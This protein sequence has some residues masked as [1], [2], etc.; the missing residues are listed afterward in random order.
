MKNLLLI[1]TISISTLVANGQNFVDPANQWNVSESQNFGATY[2]GIYKIIG[3][4]VSGDKL[5]NKIF[6]SY[7]STMINW[8]YKGLLRE[9]SN[10]VYYIPPFGNNEGL[11]YDFT[12]NAGDTIY[13]ISEWMPEPQQFVCLSVDSIFYDGAYHKRWN[14]LFP[15]EQWIEGIGSTNGPLVS[16]SSAYVSDLWFSLLCFHWND[17]LLYMGP[18]VTQCFITTVGVKDLDIAN[19]VNLSP[20]PIQRGQGLKI[21]S[22]SYSI[23]SVEI[24]NSVGLKVGEYLN[25]GNNVEI[26]ST[27]NMTTGIYLAKITTRDHLTFIKKVCV[28]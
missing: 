12:L 2:T 11:L 15:S 9:D 3:D 10:K 20:N 25:I 21:S 13:I 8:M 24:Y 18:Y 4:S 16:G 19:S 5:Y 6:V 23:N 7:D 22:D 28:Q 14:F 27:V 1:L 17:T 26:I